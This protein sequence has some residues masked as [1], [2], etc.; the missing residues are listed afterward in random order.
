MST[1]AV[2]LVLSSSVKYVVKRTLEAILGSSGQP[3]NP[4]ESEH[5]DN[6]DYC[7]REAMKNSLEE[8]EVELNEKEMES[9]GK[10]VKV[11]KDSI[12]QYKTKESELVQTIQEKD[13]EVNRLMNVNAKLIQKNYF[14]RKGKKAKDLR[15]EL[16][17][18]KLKKKV[19][20]A[21]KKRME[22]EDLLEKS[23]KE[24]KR[25]NGVVDD[26]NKKLEKT[27][28]E[29]AEKQKETENELKKFKEKEEYDTANFYA[30]LFIFLSFMVINEFQQCFLN[31]LLKSKCVKTFKIIKKQSMWGT[32]LI[33]VQN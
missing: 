31:F 7:R 8:N 2:Y 24:V 20:K 23:E 33:N 4:N 19:L 6:Q 22:E 26:L 3:F 28:R 27:T 9:S 16:A 18:F 1:D 5:A 32:N 15:K 29:M 30:F 17:N 21:E 10:D 14:G 25:L 12:A 11:L 13:K